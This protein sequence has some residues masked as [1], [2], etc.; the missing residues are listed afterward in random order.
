MD[1]RIEERALREVY[2]PHFERVVRAG[3]ASVMSAYN[4][5]NGDYCAENA[6]LLGK[7]L[8]EDWGFQGFVVSDFFRGVFDGVKAANAGLD[9]E[10]PVTQVYGRRLLEAV[11]SGEVPRAG[12]DDAARR[13]LR[14]KILYFTRPDPQTYDRGLVRSKEHLELA[15]EAA[16][17]SIVLLKNEGGVLP[18]ERSSVRTLAVMGRLAEGQRTWA[19]TARAASLPPEFVGPLVGLREYLGA[20][21][22][23][24]HDVGTDPPA[25]AASRARSTR[26]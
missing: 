18:L 13:I 17:K 23:V 14:R 25:C 12:V 7:V 10:M 6:H 19:T 24:I 21:T 26:W 11:E 22:R 20:S 1:V 16:E 9:L 3:V 4:R 15:R 8:K 2:L 5:V